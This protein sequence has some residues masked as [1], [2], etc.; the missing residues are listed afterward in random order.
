MG[1][2]GLAALHWGVYYT[3]VMWYH[4]IYDRRAFPNLGGHYVD[5][6]ALQP[7]DKPGTVSILGS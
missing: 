4:K 3:G 5:L 1:Y 7:Q 2:E 6:A